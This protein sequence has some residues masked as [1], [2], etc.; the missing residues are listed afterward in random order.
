MLCPNAGE[1]SKAFPFH[2]VIAN[3][4]AMTIQQIGPS[5]RALYPD[6][7]ISDPLDQHF[8][9]ERPKKKPSLDDLRIAIKTTFILKHHTSSLA[10]RYQLLAEQDALLFFVGSPIMNSIQEFERFGL[11]LSHFAP[12]DALPDFLMV[13]EPKDLYLKDIQNLANRLQESRDTLVNINN[14]LLSKNAE[15]AEARTLADQKNQQLI[16][17]NQSLKETQAQLIQSEKLASIGGL[18]AG[19]A[20]ELNQPLGIISL[21]SELSLEQHKLGTHQHL[22]KALQQILH[23][24]QRATTIINHLKLFGR[25]AMDLPKTPCHISRLI[26]AVL[27]LLREPLR[28]NNITLNVYCEDTLPAILCNEIQI[29]QVLTNLLSNAK[30]ALE[31]S[32]DKRIEIHC[33]QQDQQVVISIEDTGEGI[34]DEVKHR[35]FDPFYTTKEVG[36]GTGLGLS[37]CYSIIQDHQGEIQMDSTAGQGSRVTV[38]LPI[39]NETSARST[40]ATSA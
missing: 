2:I 33:Q 37:I 21:Q 23:Q 14:K 7:D 27:T 29:E 28:L 18:A 36:K 11:K 38:T 34:P 19:I 13:I 10:F 9:I 26:D 16:E 1:F 30:D 4:D 22:S 5:L 6:I 15:L 3:N 12:H 31:H 40:S 35:V 32:P 25:D 8:S 17:L 24:V 39:A 20:H